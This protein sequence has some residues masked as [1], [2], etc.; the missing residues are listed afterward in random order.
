MT[1]LLG[2]PRFFW[3]DFLDP[4][5]FARIQPASS[6]LKLSPADAAQYWQ[7][8]CGEFLGLEQH[9]LRLG[10]QMQSW[11]QACVHL[12]PRQPHLNELAHCRDQLAAVLEETSV[13]P[14]PELKFI[15]DDRGLCLDCRL[16]AALGGDRCAVA[17]RP[18]PTL[19]STTAL[20]GRQAGEWVLARR[21]CSYYEVAIGAALPFLGTAT[22][23]RRPRPQCIS[24]GLAGPAFDAF[25]LSR[26]Q[27]GWNH[28]TWGFHGDDGL[29]YH[30]DGSGF[31]FSPVLFRDPPIAACARERRLKFGEGDTVGCGLLPV[32]QPEHG[33]CL[34]VFFTLNG[35]F[36]G[37]AFILDGPHSLTWPLRACVGT[38]AHWQVTFNFGFTP[39]MFDIDELSELSSQS[40]W[41]L[42]NVT[43]S[44][45]ETD[46]S[47]YTSDSDY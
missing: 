28:G 8:R 24:V 35:T 14:P 43:H 25:G 15:M 12:S 2:V 36:L 3:L 30:G 9:R 39:F 47:D 6:A 21:S 38:D 19:H 33:D 10:S 7:G 13:D 31:Q 40:P 1:S 17:S 37:V 16:C 5:E 46:Y 42:A 27:C 29:L 45:T 11:V 18:L 32:K 22:V 23:H 34:G 44:I 20:A 41:V 26:Q 4:H